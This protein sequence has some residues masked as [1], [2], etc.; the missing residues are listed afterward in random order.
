MARSRSRR[1]AGR[2]QRIVAIIVLICLGL[3]GLAF[4]AA[5][6]VSPRQAPNTVQV[7]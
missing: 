7:L 3:S 4:Y 5:A 6:N 1:R 2:A